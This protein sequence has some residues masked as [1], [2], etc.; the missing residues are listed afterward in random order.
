MTE[1][2]QAIKYISGLKYPIQERVILHHVFS[3]DKAHNKSLK[4]RD[5]KVGLHLSGV[6]HQLKN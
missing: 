5:Y 1:E 3:I 2:Q 4:S 6:Q